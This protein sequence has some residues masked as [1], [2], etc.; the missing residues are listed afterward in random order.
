MQKV[1][2]AMKVNKNTFDFKDLLHNRVLLYVFLLISL[3]HLFYYVNIG[4][5]RSAA[6]FILIGFLTSFFSKNMLVILII[7][8]VVTHIMKF[9]L[10]SV[11]EGLENKEEKEEKEEAKEGL[12]EEEKEGLEGEEEDKKEGMKEG[13]DKGAVPPKAKGGVKPAGEKDLDSEKK[14]DY[15]EFQGLQKEIMTNMQK[16]EPLIT[17][18]ESFVEKYHE[19]YGSGNKKD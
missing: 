18:A 10:R 9:G 19:K 3:V 4:D 1:N 2:S 8:L 5:M 11:S 7:A 15:L 17:K 13:K 16:L 12:E 6:I 14:K